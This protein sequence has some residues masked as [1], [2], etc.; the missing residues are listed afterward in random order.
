MF[1]SAKRDAMAESD[2]IK[3]ARKRGYSNPEWWAK[4]VI[5]GRQKKANRLRLVTFKGKP[6]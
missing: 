3:L 6:V 2:L 1:D 4:K 5:A